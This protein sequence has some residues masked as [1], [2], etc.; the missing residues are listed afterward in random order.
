MYR[1][2]STTHSHIHHM[3]LPPRHLLPPPPSISAPHPA[4]H[5]APC[6]FLPSHRVQ[7]ELHGFFGLMS[8]FVRE[9]EKAARDNMAQDKAEA[10]LAARNA[11]NATSKTVSMGAVDETAAST[12]A[13][14]PVHKRESSRQLSKD[15]DPK[16][17]FA[18]FSAFQL[19]D[20]NDIVD[21]VRHRD[22]HHRGSTTT[23]DEWA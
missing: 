5:Y 18:A 21:Q 17:I 3:N 4:F 9:L 8:D 7:T 20:A 12:S 15:A 22:S 19:S 16:D 2:P 23:I 10:V 13:S 11:K 14:I 1:V 6:S